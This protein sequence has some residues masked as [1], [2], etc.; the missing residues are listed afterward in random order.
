LVFFGRALLLVVVVAYGGALRFDAISQKYDPVTAPRWLQRLEVS[1]SGPSLLR[2]AQLRWGAYPRVAHKDGPPSQYRSD[3]Y[4]YLQYAREM[5]SFYAAHRREPLFPFATKLSLWLLHDSDSAVSFASASFSV[6]AIVLTFALGAEVFSFWV[7]VGAALLW[8]IEADAIH[9]GTDGWRDDAFTCAV[10]LS[11]LLMVRYARQP[12]MQRAVML[13]AAAGFAC[14]VRITALSFLVPAFGWLLVSAGR[15]W[16]SRVKTLGTS[17]AV[18]LLAVGPFLVNCWRAFGDPLYSINV[19]ANVYRATAGEAAGDASAQ[20]YIGEHL[21]DQP[22]ETIDTFVL[23]LTHYP[24]ANKWNGFEPWGQRL[25]SLLAA[26]ALS[27]LFLWVALPEGRLLLFVLAA[28]LA[29]YALTWRLIF[30]WRFTEHAYPFFLVAASSTPWFLIQAITRRRRLFED[31]MRARAALIA[32]MVTA[33]ASAAIAFVFTRVTPVL[34]FREAVAAGRPATIMAGDR[35]TAF[36]GNEWPRVVQGGAIATRVAAG[37]RATIVLPLPAAADY[38]ALIRVDPAQ[39][40]LRQGMVAAPIQLLLNGRL[41][42]TCDSGSTPDRIGICRVVLPADAART[43]ANRLTVA[44]SEPSGFRVWYVR[45][46]RK[47]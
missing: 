14:L 7:G 42:G 9:F 46:T 35:D 31:R 27:G 47:S 21:R 2:P 17:A 18:M 45:V 20:R 4:T 12:S 29:P 19:H 8:A 10:L 25:P 6:L 26:A 24:F 13:G 43:G 34:M 41:I 22:I 44:T 1:R 28:S 39:A 16:R 3:P 15:S 30:D 32:W 11:A 38:D 36:F 40:P 5:R 33:A 37:T 23:G